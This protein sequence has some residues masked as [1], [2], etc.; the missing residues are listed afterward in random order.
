MIFIKSFNNNVALVE[1]LN[2]TEWVVIGNGIGFGKK[3]GDSIDDSKITRRFIA[4]D[5]DSTE[6]NTLTSISEQTII[7]TN[8]VVKLVEPYL[9]VKFNSYQYLALADHIEFALQRAS[10]AVDLADGTTRWSVQKLFPQEYEAAEQSVNLIQQMTGSQLSNGEVV[11]IAYHFLNL[12]TDAPG[13]HDTIKITK[14]IEQVVDI[15]QYEYGVNLDSDSF[16]FNRFITHLR[17]FMIQH[18]KMIN[19]NNDDLDPAILKLMI[20]KYPQAYQTVER[21]D[22]FLQ[23][24]VGW[25][26]Q[27]D[28][29]VYLTLHIWRVTHR[30]IS[31]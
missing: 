18:L 25:Q 22:G 14:L 20:A 24:K 30:Q 21:I 10:T 17:S 8:E 4:A 1:D 11:L 27:P 28:E 19:S 2:N 31:E 15:V 9:S 26:L 7:V 29:K 12:R 6:L 16:N 23:K 3:T 5:A 13:L